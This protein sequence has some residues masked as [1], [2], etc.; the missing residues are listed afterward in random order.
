MKTS[1]SEP[2]GG[3]RTHF[4]TATSSVSRYSLSTT[5]SSRLTIP[6][7]DFVDKLPLKDDREPS[8]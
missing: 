5:T 8:R 1:G 2:V 6:T 3:R 7:S 4:G